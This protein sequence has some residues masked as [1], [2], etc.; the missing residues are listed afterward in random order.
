M[1]N[2]IAAS[3]IMSVGTG[4]GAGMLWSSHVACC[5]IS[6]CT[7]IYLCWGYVYINRRAFVAKSRFL[8]MA[9][10][11]GFSAAVFDMIVN[12]RRAGTSLQQTS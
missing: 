7:S 8:C 5:A 9:T 3:Y 11:L 2:V 1:I 4:T 10:S 12:K 6:R